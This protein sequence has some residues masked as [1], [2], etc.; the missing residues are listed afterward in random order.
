MISL[1]K[2]CYKSVFAFAF[3]LFFALPN[4]FAGSFFDGSVA[5]EGWAFS[6]LNFTPYRE[7]INYLARN[8]VVAGYADGTFKPES[9]VNRAELLKILLEGAGVQKSG[10]NCYPDVKNEWFA[11]YVCKAK[12][13]GIVSGYPDGKFRPEQQVTFS[14]LSK[15]VVI[16]NKLQVEPVHGKLELTFFNGVYDVTNDNTWFYPYVKALEAKKAIPMAVFRFDAKMTRGQVAELI[17][18]IKADVTDNSSNTY[19]RIY[20]IEHFTPVPPRGISDEQFTKL[21]TAILTYID[22]TNKKYA[23]IDYSLF[24]AEYSKFEMVNGPVFA[25]VNTSTRQYY[26]FPDIDNESVKFLSSIDSNESVLMV[27]GCSV[28]ADKNH[29]YFIDDTNT[30]RALNGIDPATIVIVQADG[31]RGALLKDKNGIY[32]AY[33]CVFALMNGVDAATFKAY[34]DVN[35]EISD[36]FYYKDR[37]HVYYRMNN[38]QLGI[39]EGADPLTFDKLADRNGAQLRGYFKDKNSL[40]SA[41]IPQNQQEEDEDFFYL[42]KVEQA[43]PNTFIG[44]PYVVRDNETIFGLDID[45]KL[46]PYPAFDLTKVEQIYLTDPKFLSAEDDIR[47]YGLSV[48][49]DKDHVYSFD[50]IDNE[51]NFHDEI[52]VTSFELAGSHPYYFK[53]KYKYYFVHPE[54]QDLVALDVLSNQEIEIISDNGSNQ[55]FMV[56]TADKLYMFSPEESKFTL[57]D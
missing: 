35:A 29:M 46:I 54:H 30:I 8:K 14:E 56:K 1:R 34:G 15:M 17:G 47:Y 2:Y 16:T 32:N 39:L 26:F 43:D 6:D 44:T 31:E 12:E 25:L 24:H 57:V 4:T 3:G 5:G 49:K 21:K 41:Y 23:S 11:G 55:K 53:D 27:A 40:Y 38:S 22:E 28:F 7:A 52:D 10:E 50:P 13:L 37:N 33:D 42:Y 9:N 45:G 36:I 18:R 48:F 51:L 19:S 20:D